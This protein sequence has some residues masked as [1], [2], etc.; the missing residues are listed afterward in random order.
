[1]FM[2]TLAE[3]IQDLNDLILQG[4]ILEAFEIYYHPEVSMQ[5]NE[6]EPTI[7]KTANRQR[8]EAFVAAVTEIRS[9]RVLKTTVGE[10][11]SMVEWQFDYT[12]KDWGV[13]HYKQVS[14]QEWKDGLIIHE[15]FYYNA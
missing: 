14:V 10:N 11:C 4:K 7:G 8:E 1:M 9:A 5:E 6:N 2:T 3:K 13:R 12:H 15:K